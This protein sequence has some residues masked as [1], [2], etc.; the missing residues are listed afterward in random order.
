MANIG[1][2]EYLMPTES[3]HDPLT[4]G[5]LKNI[6]PEHLRCS[7]G[8]CPA[9]YE[10]DQ[11]TVVIV[12]AAADIDIKA[13]VG[14]GEAAVLVKKELLANVFPHAYGETKKTA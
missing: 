12:G 6:T 10:V 11:D 3:L 1:I 13:L 9:V 14:D 4:L 2:L 7:I 8:A 5:Y